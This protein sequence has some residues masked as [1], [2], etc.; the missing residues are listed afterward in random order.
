MISA[1][2]LPRDPRQ[3]LVPL[4][5]MTALLYSINTFYAWSLFYLHDYRTKLIHIKKIYIVCSF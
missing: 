5:A 1:R 3:V 4:G 2:N